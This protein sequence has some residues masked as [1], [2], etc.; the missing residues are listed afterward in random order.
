MFCITEQSHGTTSSL[1]LPLSTGPPLVPRRHPEPVSGVVER[2]EP[3]DPVP[4]PPAGTSGPGAGA[5]SS[6]GTCLL[7]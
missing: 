7:A 2:W 3:G 4:V 6:I 5:G 1:G